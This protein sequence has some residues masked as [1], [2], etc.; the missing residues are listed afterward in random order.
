MTAG[1]ISASGWGV[2]VS[3]C[4]CLCACL[5][6]FVIVCVSDCISHPAACLLS[7]LSSPFLRLLLFLSVC[8]REKAGAWLN[9]SLN[10]FTVN[11]IGALTVYQET[12]VC[13][14]VCLFACLSVWSSWSLLS[15]QTHRWLINK[16]W[17]MSPQQGF[18]YRWK[19][20][21]VLVFGTFHSFRKSKPGRRAN[22]SPVSL[23]QGNRAQ[24]QQA[25]MV[26]G[27]NGNRM[28]FKVNNQNITW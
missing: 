7:I 18:S 5:C 6:L 3:V 21:W 19:C 8:E 14:S 20:V 22:R 26:L 9:L 27:L 10:R 4:E 1:N 17:S 13:L 2:D 28:H 23:R 12:S 16:Q 15:T 25:D 24:N 11:L